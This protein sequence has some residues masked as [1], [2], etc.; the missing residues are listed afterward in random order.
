MAIIIGREAPEVVT[1]NAREQKTEAEEQS[2]GA[3][4]NDAVTEEMVE[5]K[6]RKKSAVRRKKGAKD[7]Q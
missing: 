2:A 3:V 4:L 6:P 5:A 1:D 7:V